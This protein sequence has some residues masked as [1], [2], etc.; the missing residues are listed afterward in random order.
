MKRIKK[1]KERIL[2]VVLTFMMVVSLFSGMTA[3]EV[4]AATF[5][6]PV[7]DRETITLYESGC[8]KDITITVQASG[9]YAT[10][11]GRIG[12]HNGTTAY[13]WDHRFITSSNCTSWPEESEFVNRDS[14]FIAFA[15][16]N[17]FL[18]TDCQQHTIT[19]TFADGKVDLS[20]DQ[21]Y[22]IYLWTRA[23]AYG[24]Y[25]DA[26]LGTL[27]TK[28]GK[29]LD[30]NGNTLIDSSTSTEGGGS[31]SNDAK[32]VFDYAYDCQRS[33]A[34]PTKGATVALRG[35]KTP[36]GASESAGKWELTDCGKYDSS[37]HTETNAATIASVVSKLSGQYGVSNSDINVFDLQKDGQHIC[38]GV[39]ATVFGE[40]I[41]FIGT[42]HSGGAGY[43]LCNKALS[44]SDSITDTA[45]GDT[46]YIPT[47]GETHTHTM[48][49]KSSNPATCTQAGNIEY[50]YCGD[51]DK[52]YSDANG[53]TEITLADAVITALGH[54]WSGEWTTIKEAT[55]TEEG[56]KATLCVRSC[57]QKKVVAIPAIGTS[58]EGAIEKDAE[59]AQDAPFEEVTFDNT[60]AELFEAIFDD[61][62]KQAIEDGANARVWLEISELDASTLEDEAVAEIEEKATGIMGDNLHITYFDA[63]LFKQVGAAVAPVSQPG[64]DIKITIKI[65][66][67]LLNTN[68]AI[69]R[70]YKILRLHEGDT[71]AEAISGTFNAATGEFTFVTDRFSTYAIV[72][73]DTPVTNPGG[74]PSWTNTPSDTNLGSNVKDEVPDTG[75]NNI[76][77]YSFILMVLSAVG[78]FFATE[79]R[80]S[81]K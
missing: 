35:F 19:F 80:K 41:L 77:P 6:T 3:T 43:Y 2:S 33:P 75:E 72:Y 78:I 54:D 17:E 9:S 66:N 65:P 53:N 61:T 4:Q 44:S 8:L 69:I 34:Y 48:V 26:H 15:S 67:G 25:T 21:T 59:V 63:N 51:C 12:I 11:Y 28:D 18:W 24:I 32:Y 56:K 14:S 38:Y 1:L 76:L 46:T 22:H 5:R 55:A 57:G 70:E 40:G 71:E 79:K 81:Y 27:Q 10:A 49:A 39:V 50:Y 20:K 30:E 29:L 58:E 23:N 13:D 42:T 47:P 7:I 36:L 73:A 62:E 52:L 68:G 31:E 16:G 64:V 45:I 37:I 74:N 60:K